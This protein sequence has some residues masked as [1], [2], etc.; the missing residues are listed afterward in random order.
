MIESPEHVAWCRMTF[1]S[2]VEGGIWGVP[3]S[4]LMFRRE[5]E[6]LWQTPSMPYHPE[7]PITPE[8]LDEQQAGEID[9]ISEHFAAAGITVFRLNYDGTHTEEEL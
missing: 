5:G 7:M 6:T 9:A 1:D 8:Q 4:G 3:R 2:L